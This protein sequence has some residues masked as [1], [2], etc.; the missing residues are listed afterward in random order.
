MV[1]VQIGRNGLVSCGAADRLRDLR[2]QFDREHFVR[3]PQLLEP[4]LLSFIQTEIERGEFYE[5]IHEGIKSNKELCLKQN[6]AYGALLLF[7]NDDNLFRVIQSIAQCA[8]IRC[9]EGR[10]YRLVPGQGHHDAW[11]GDLAEDRLVALS[12][13]LSTEPYE[14]GT[15]QIRDAASGSTVREV[16]NPGRG[17]AVLFRLAPQLQHRITEIEG[18][19]RKTAF[20]GWFKAQPD[21][22]TLLKATDQT[23]SFD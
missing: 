9:F 12:I 13:N 2:R 1:P 16:S 5:R 22:L 8:A 6:T 19:A 3:L 7:M 11:H 23:T 17:D 20:A 4:S 21:F 14:G 18:T 10:I 15:L